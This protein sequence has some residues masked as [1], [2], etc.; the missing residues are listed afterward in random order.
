[1]ETVGWT[2]VVYS[3]GN[4]LF[5]IHAGRIKHGFDPWELCAGYAIEAGL[6]ASGVGVR[7]VVGSIPFGSTKVNK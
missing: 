7:Q 2:S 4:F 1:M 3:M 5:D 6:T